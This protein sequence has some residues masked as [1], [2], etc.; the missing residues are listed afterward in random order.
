[1]KLDRELH[2]K[3]YKEYWAKIDNCSHWAIKK[4][5]EDIPR[6]MGELPWGENERRLWTISRAAERLSEVKDNGFKDA[7]RRLK[8]VN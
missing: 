2:L 4:A 8:N 6:E 3:R 7:I 5:A 1:M